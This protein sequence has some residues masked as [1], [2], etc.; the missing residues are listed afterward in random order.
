MNSGECARK[1]TEKS[2]L[3]VCVMRVPRCVFV[4]AK[5]I[6]FLILKYVPFWRYVFWNKSKISLLLIHPCFSIF[7]SPAITLVSWEL[8]AEYAKAKCQRASQPHIHQREISFFCVL[9]SKTSQKKPFKSH[10]EGT[11]TAI[12]FDHKK[13]FKLRLFY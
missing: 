12:Y 5:G 9:G 10:L 6:L 3:C 8:Q 11:D 2:K 1:L 13:W 4:C 7:L